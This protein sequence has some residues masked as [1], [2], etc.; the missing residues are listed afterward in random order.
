ML[1]VEVGNEPWFEVT[2]DVL[3]L[4]GHTFHRGDLIPGLAL[5]DRR[6]LMM[7][8]GMVRAVQAGRRVA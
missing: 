6:A 4:D 5:G 7:R 2:S 8:L 1:S 3:F